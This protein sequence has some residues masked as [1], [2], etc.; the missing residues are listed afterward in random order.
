M[1][2]S[3]LTPLEI[4]KAMLTELM[5]MKKVLSE[6][7]ILKPKIKRAERFIKELSEI[8]NLPMPQELVPK[9]PISVPTH[10]RPE[11]ITVDDSLTCPEPDCGRAFATE[12]GLKVHMARASCDLSGPT[13]GKNC[14]SHRGRW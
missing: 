1:P 10:P 9:E 11:G 5:R 3:P 7:E 2:D 12:Q 8:W 13:H 4:Q 14:E 6:A